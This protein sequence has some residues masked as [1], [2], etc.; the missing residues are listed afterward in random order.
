MISK[1]CWSGDELLWKKGREG[2]RSILFIKVLK[3]LK[4]QLSVAP[5]HFKNATYRNRLV[6]F[7][8]C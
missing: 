1:T 6:M 3:A 4:C 8:L 5:K 7:A 2:R